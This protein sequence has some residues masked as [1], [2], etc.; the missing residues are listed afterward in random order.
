[1][2]DKKINEADKSHLSAISSEAIAIVGMSCRFPGVASSTDG[3]WNLLSNGLHVLSEIPIERFDSSKYFAPNLDAVNKTYV[4]TGAFIESVAGFDANFFRISPREAIAMDPQQRILLECSWEALEDYGVVPDTLANSNTGVF[5]GCIDSEYKNLLET[6]QNISEYEPLIPTGAFVGAV[7]GRLSYTFGFSGPSIVVDTHYSA[8]LV[9]LHLACQSLRCRECDLALAGGVHFILSPEGYILFSRNRTLS[10]EGYSKT[11]DASANGFGRGEGCGVLVLK[12]LSDANRDGD[13]VHAV[14]LGSAVNQDGHSLSMAAPNGD[15]QI[16]LLQEA[17]ARAKIAPN[18][19]GYIEAHGTGTPLGDPIEAQAIT[20]VFKK[21]R[22]HASPLYI[23]SVKT[24]IGHLEAASGIA[25]VIKTILALKYK[26]IPPHLHFNKLNPSINFGDLNAVI[27]TKLTQWEPI[28]GRRIAGV[29]SFGITGTNAH[30]VIEEA[31]DEAETKRL[32]NKFDRTRHIL[33][34]SAQSLY[35]LQELCQKYLNFDQGKSL[36]DISFSANNYRSKF[37][38]RLAVIARDLF[39]F[40][41]KLQ[42]WLDCHDSNSVFYGEVTAKKIPKIAFLFTGQ[43]AQYSGMGQ[44]L[45]VTSTVFKNSLDECAAIMQKNRYLDKPLLSVLWGEHSNLINE[46]Q[47]TQPALFA[48]EY[49]LYKLWVSWG[50]IPDAVIG[51]SVGE[52]VAACVAGVFS[53]EDGLKLI[54]RRA[55]LMQALPKNGAMAAINLSYDAVKDFIIDYDK[56][57]S[58]AAINGLESIVISGYTD[59]IH[60]I[61]SIC[62]KKAIKTKL[63]K[64]SHAFHSHLLEPMLANFKTVLADINF[65]KPTIALVSNLTGKFVSEDVTSIDYWLKHTRETVKFSD[66]VRYLVDEKIHCFVEIGPQPLLLAMA[67]ESLDDSSLQIFLPSMRENNDCWEQILNS[68][69]KL[70][71]CGVPI[72]WKDFDKDYKRNR[73]DLPTYAFQRQRYWVSMVKSDVISQSAMADKSLE[74]QSNETLNPWLDKVL[75]ASYADRKELIQQRLQCEIIRILRKGPS[76]TIDVDANLDAIGLDSLLIIEFRTI[77]K[78]T[79]NRLLDNIVNQS[80]FTKYKTIGEVSDVISIELDANKLQHSTPYNNLIHTISISNLETEIDYRVSSEWIKSATTAED[81][82]L[83]GWD[84]LFFEY[85]YIPLGFLFDGLIDCDVFKN[86]LIRA[87]NAIP[88]YSG[89]VVKNENGKSVIRTK[90][91]KGVLFEH[92]V[93]VSHDGPIEGH[94]SRAAWKHCFQWGILKQ[95][96]DNNPESPLLAIKVIH[97]PKSN[98]S[99]VCIYFSHIVGDVATI[100][101]F[102]SKW[103]NKSSDAINFDRTYNNLAANLKIIKPAFLRSTISLIKYLRYRNVHKVEIIVSNDRIKQL[104]AMQIDYNNLLQLYDLVDLREIGIVPEH[105]IGNALDY[106]ESGSLF[107]IGIFLEKLSDR[108]ELSTFINR[109]R[110]G[111]VRIGLDGMLLDIINIAVETDGPNEFGI[112]NQCTSIKLSDEYDS[113]SMSIIY[114]RSSGVHVMRATKGLFDYLTIH[115]MVFESLPE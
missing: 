33:T 67:K 106:R 79:F 39:D 59:H 78:T 113:A 20:E 94:V 27:P 8:S 49:A 51:H 101:L 35:S 93:D 104:V 60:D 105:Y 16:N 111:S 28:A 41:N 109:S 98:R 70:Y 84:H 57:V 64:V 54:S 48:F 72:N 58:V 40:K 19:I 21:D 73:V 25:G 50:V 10:P 3:Y 80:F 108:G 114:N 17:L 65:S 36:A 90:H 52:Y 7:A 55:L 82:A 85:Q 91:T 99:V 56:T 45:Y 2:I 61:V 112:A 46:T 18:Q 88:L 26:Q 13:R 23:G 103:R 47:F 86:N 11:F 81:I 32:P 87:L 53:L 68:L 71:V 43:G 29:S 24:N 12:R 4:K 22:S 89:R 102:L 62:D 5:I 6:S 66:G 14:I 63:L 9:A 15:A 95:H 75:K 100:N 96:R 34:I 44:Q 115:G 107:N 1:M 37:K 42:E 77:L 31:V 92:Y 74:S 69:A 76:H 97:F 110:W 30:V 38:H 83:F